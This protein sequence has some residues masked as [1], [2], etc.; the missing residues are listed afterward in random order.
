MV[1]P[2]GGAIH[3]VESVA[4]RTRY[5][6]GAF[7]EAG[8]G[9]IIP[10]LNAALKAFAPFQEVYIDW[11]NHDTPA[12]AVEPD[13]YPFRVERDGSSLPRHKMNLIFATCGQADALVEKGYIAEA[14][15][16]LYE[17]A[18]LEPGADIVWDRIK[19]LA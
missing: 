10:R 19:A 13:G 4:T 16:L 5:T 15:R 8:V 11:V 12:P 18:L 9:Q 2:P 17:A 1:W 7:E 3:S 6:V 14:K